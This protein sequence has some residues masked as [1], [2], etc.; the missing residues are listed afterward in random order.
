MMMIPQIAHDC[1][2]GFA[3]REYGCIAKVR[4]A[5]GRLE[6]VVRTAKIWIQQ[7]GGMVGGEWAARS[8]GPR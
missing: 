1:Q 8:V 2:K 3:P 7:Q 6:R 4:V 5:K